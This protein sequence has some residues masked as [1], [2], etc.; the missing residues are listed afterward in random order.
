MNHS[1]IFTALEISSENS[2]LSLGT[3]WLT[4]SGDITESHS[5][6]DGK[7]IATVKN[8][9]IADYEIVVKKA[10]EAFKTWKTFPAP[11]RGEVVRQIG[12]ALREKKQEL[13]YLVSLEMGKIFQEGLGEV[14]EMIDI[15]DFAV[16]QSRLLN[17]YTM[18]YCNQSSTHLALL[19]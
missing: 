19:V 1:K 13:G 12:L 14:Q 10:E 5:P 17:G 9:S 18:P 7:L 4:A 16:G 2:G 6:I 3:K 8:A 11:A 15:C